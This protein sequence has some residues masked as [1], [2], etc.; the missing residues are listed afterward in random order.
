MILPMVIK[1]AESQCPADNYSPCSCTTPFLGF[2]VTCNSASVYEIMKS[3][4]VISPVNAKTTIQKLTLI[5]RDQDRY[6]P[7]NLLG[8]RNVTSL[9]IKC[10]LQNT[11]SNYI[12]LDRNALMAS[13]NSLT[14]LK[15]KTCNLMNLDWSFLTDFTSL[16]NLYIVH[17]SNFHETF[18][19]LPPLKSLTDFALETMV[20]N[21][22][23][24]GVMKYPKLVNGL[25]SVSISWNTDPF[26]STKFM[27]DFLKWLA[28]SS[29]K[30][31]TTLL[32]S[33]DVLSS[34]TSQI[35]SFQNLVNLYTFNNAA[36]IVIGKG[37][38]KFNSPPGVVYSSL[39]NINRITD[40]A[41]VG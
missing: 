38:L 9:V 19:T 25:T 41:F 8:N 18:Y 5:M 21:C 2:G 23:S 27:N 6:I 3:Q 17:C 34:V 11:K 37:D 22:Y 7:A 28:V 35:G 39:S 24:S 4:F 15:I 30:T 14:E 16:K 12:N 20:I 26:F 29:A 33:A 1:I 36:P 40:G 13:K 31:L 32:L 10:H